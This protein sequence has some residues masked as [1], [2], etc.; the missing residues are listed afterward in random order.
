MSRSFIRVAQ[1]L[2]A[3]SFNAAIILTIDFTYDNEHEFGPSNW[4][5]LSPLCDEGTRQSPTDLIS[6]NV[7]LGNVFAPLEIYG[8]GKF[9]IAITIFNDA[10]T[11]GIKFT[12]A[13]GF[14]VQLKSGPLGYG[15]TYLVDR[16]HWRWGES[17]WGGS[18]HTIN[19]FRYSA[20]THIV[21]Y[22]S[23]YRE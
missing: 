16:V 5:K 18:E 11:Y 14:K 1:V 23:K 22:N 20:E 10:R 8:D 4:S 19:G 15:E 13:D 9:P 2:F 3:F 12:Y 17:D 7:L 6:S 21:S